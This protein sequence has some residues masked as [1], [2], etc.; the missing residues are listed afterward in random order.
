LPEDSRARLLRN[1]SLARLKF[2]DA[3]VAAALLFTTIGIFNPP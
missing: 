3:L 1:E 2:N